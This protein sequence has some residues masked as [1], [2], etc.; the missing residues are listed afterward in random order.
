ML[1]AIIPVLLIIFISGCIGFGGGATGDGVVILD[2]KPDFPSVYSGEPVKLQLRVQNLGEIDAENTEAQLTNIKL[3]KWGSMGVV[4]KKNLGKLIAYDPANPDVPG[5]VRTVE[6]ALEA[7]KLEKGLQWTYTPMVKVSYDYKT[8]ATKSITIVDQNELRRIMQQGRSLPAQATVVTKG[9]L[10]IEIRTGDYVKTTS[11]FTAGRVYDIFPIYIKITN[12]GIG[13]GGT[14]VRNGFAGFFGEEFDYPVEVKITPP[15]GTS[16]VY[17][18]TYGE[19]DCSTGTVTVDL[20]QGKEKEITCELQVDEVPEF[21]TEGL[22]TVEVS[23]RYQVEASTQ[24]K[25]F[26][27]KE[28]F[29]L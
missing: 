16:F 24:I 4:E 29:G 13:A 17:S 26:G 8:R 12:K 20:W 1:K 21:R 7:P 18:G 11:R 27:K 9:P 3:S 28:R 22:I 10:D 2:F 19:D 5:A 23:Y 14:V 15:S 6:W 25:V